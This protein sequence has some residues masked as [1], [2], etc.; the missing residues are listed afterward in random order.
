[1]T[2]M[3]RIKKIFLILVGTLLPLGATLGGS[4]LGCGCGS[5]SAS[6]PPLS[7][8]APV[9]GIVS[10]TSPDEDGVALVAGD[11]DAVEGGSL[12]QAINETQA[13]SVAFLL[14]S[15]IPSAMADGDLPAVCSLPFHV[16]AYAEDD[17]SF[18]IEITA[19]EDDEI[20]VGT[21]DPTSGD[22]T[23]EKTRK[24][25][26][27]NIRHFVLPVTDVQILPDQQKL[28]ALVQEPSLENEPSFVTVLDLATNERTPIPFAGSDPRRMRFSPAKDTAIILD[29]SGNFAAVADVQLRNFLNPTLFDIE[30]P[31]DV[32]FADNGET[33]IVSSG[34]KSDTALTKIDL[35]Q[36]AVAGT[37]KSADITAGD[38][39]HEATL[40]LDITT[41]AVANAAGVQQGQLVVAVMALTQ[42]ETLRVGL[43][44]FD[45]D[46]LQPVA[47]ITEFPEGTEP[48][49]VA[50]HPG[51][52]KILV[53]DF[54]NDTVLVY[55][56][57]FNPG[58]QPPVTVSLQ[59]TVVDPNGALIDPRD[60][61]VDTVN[62]YAFVSAR[63][64]TE[65]RPDSV[66][67]I[68]LSNDTVVQVTPVGLNPTGMDWDEQNSVLYVST[69]KTHAVTFWGA[70]DL[71]P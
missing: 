29:Q 69:A 64:H 32:I 33:A 25:V 54:G 56:Y 14:S 58:A 51:A 62:G 1:M 7:I 65:N 6:A 22:E 59:G 44:L 57:E 17:G 10:V 47:A 70:A 55:A 36:E 15:L 31:L 66:V 61:Q 37:V 68:D 63:N 5:L 71:L 46:T 38:I 39:S 45:Y 26:P 19:A 18:E 12:V 21:I 49:D 9:S 11:S 23:S 35:V 67:T 16:C 34:N 20:S 50:F 43:S 48:D 52:N 60:V 42:G 4:V 13:S 30:T 3:D 28:F 53:T 2:R 40:A 24:P 41:F 8:P 27:Q